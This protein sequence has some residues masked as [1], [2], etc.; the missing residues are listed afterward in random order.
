LGFLSFFVRRYYLNKICNR[1]LGWYFYG[2][3]WGWLEQ[4]E[5]SS[6]LRVQLQDA[7][8]ITTSI[9]VVGCR[10][11]SNQLLIW[12]LKMVLVAL[13]DKLMG[14]TDKV[15]VIDAAETIHDFAS[16]EIPGASCALSPGLDFILRVRPHHVRETPFVGDLCDPQDGLYLLESGN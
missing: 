8:Q 11:H 5:G 1:F 12:A 15:Q 3:L 7:R 6:V 14:S 9:T 16:K 4:F 10:P 2:G 13:I